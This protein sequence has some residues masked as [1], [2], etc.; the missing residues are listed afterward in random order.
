MVNCCQCEGIKRQFGRKTA[1]RVL[2]A[3]R[4]ERRSFRRTLA[5]ELAVYSR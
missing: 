4:L 5:W 3:H 2:R 1:M